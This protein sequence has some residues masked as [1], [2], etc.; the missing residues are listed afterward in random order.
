[1]LIGKIDVEVIQRIWSA[2]HVLR[3]WK[4]EE[5]NVSDEIITE[6]MLIDVLIQSSKEQ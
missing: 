2:G 1:L 4:V 3:A 6:Q 5:I